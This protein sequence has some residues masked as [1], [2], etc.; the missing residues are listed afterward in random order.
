LTNRTRRHDEAYRLIRLALELDPGSAPVI[1]SMGWVLYRKGRLDEARSYLEL[2]L[3]QLEDPEIMAHL[4][5]VLWVSDERERALAIWD[6]G[7]VDYPDSQPLIE[8][9]LRFVN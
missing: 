8:T 9:R 6:K 5:E 3:S 4:G 2:A 7:L 1:D